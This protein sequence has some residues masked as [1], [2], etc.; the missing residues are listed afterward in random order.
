MIRWFGVLCLLF[1]VGCEMDEPP[2]VDLL[3]AHHAEYDSSQ[4]SDLSNPNYVP[5]EDSWRLSIDEKW[6][7]NGMAGLE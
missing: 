4:L 2:R 1:V 7:S 6:P 5:K 3:V